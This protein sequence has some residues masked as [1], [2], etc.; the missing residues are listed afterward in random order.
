MN[1][2]ELVD[3]LVNSPSIRNSGLKREFIE[4]ILDSYRDHLV[5]I[6]LENGYINLGNGFIIE[7]V[8]LTERVHV[9]RGVSYKSSRKYKLKLSMEES[10]YKKIESYYEGLCEDIS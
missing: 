6:M 3:R 5:D 4:K 8:K 2:E 1:N 7:I 9:L 10:I